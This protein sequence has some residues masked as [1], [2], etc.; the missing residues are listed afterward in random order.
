MDSGP[1]DLS[2][3]IASDACAASTSPAT[4]KKHVGHSPT[5]RKFWDKTRINRGAQLS[6]NCVTAPP[7]LPGS[8][9]ARGPSTC[10]P[11]TCHV[12]P[13]TGV[14]VASYHASAPPAPRACQ[15]W[16]CHVASVPRC[17]HALVPRAILARRLGPLATSSPA[18]SSSLFCDLNKEKYIKKS[19][20]N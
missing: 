19:I 10:E 6:F 1:R 16:L 2:H 8:H 11:L 18:V 17:I 20:K 7:L 3:L 9:Y 12:A 5:R 15:S 4:G 13:L 14:R